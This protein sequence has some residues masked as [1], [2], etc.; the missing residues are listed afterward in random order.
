M[1]HMTGAREEWMTARLDLLET[2]SRLKI[3]STTTSR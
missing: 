1:M 3:R 2:D